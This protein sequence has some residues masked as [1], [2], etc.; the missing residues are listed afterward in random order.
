MFIVGNI[1]NENERKYVIVI[2]TRIFSGHSPIKET[3]LVDDIIIYQ[4]KIDVTNKKHIRLGNKRIRIPQELPRL[5]N[6]SVYFVSC[7]GQNTKIYNYS[8]PAKVY[9]VSNN[10]D[11]WKKLYDNIKKDTNPYK[12]IIHMGDQVYIDDAHKEILA[13]KCNIPRIYYNLYKRNFNKKY[14]K[15]VLANAFNIMVCDDHEIVDNY[16]S[17]SNS[18]TNE[19]LQC[20]KLLYNSIQSDLYGM[21]SRQIKHLLFSDFQ[22]IIP[23]LRSHRKP[24]TNTT[25]E[26][27]IM[28]KRQMSEF[29]AIV[30]KNKLLTYYVSSIPL[31][32]I[33][34]VTSSSIWSLSNNRF[35]YQIDSYI[36]SPS[37]T[38]ERNYILNKLFA[39]DGK[40]LI[41]SG[42]SHVS[43]SYTLTKGNKS[44]RQITASPISSDPAI[45]PNSPIYE[46]AIGYVLAV[47][48]YDRKICDIAITKQWH[49]YD[50]N[51]LKITENV[52]KLCCYN[53]K[54]TI[55]IYG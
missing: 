25:S 53:D 15:L 52:M 20:A 4:Y 36:A 9:N 54:N 2:S 10:D 21:E 6:T 55:E 19:M 7:D 12:F 1:F 39:I 44:I 14:K 22:I 17:V 29:D 30:D 45:K 48:A 46:K 32:G 16:N 27:P 47:C 31:I 11:M 38:R 18:M 13:N 5:S 8:S 37:Y 34:A 43:D 42:D 40:V 28:G 3:R 26:F 35:D 49:R 23:D 24:N 41:I 50:Y 51:Y 33:D